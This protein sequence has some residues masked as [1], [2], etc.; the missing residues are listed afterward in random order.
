M[1]TTTT[2][3]DGDCSLDEVRPG[4]SV[5]AVVS[6]A[7]GNESAIGWVDGTDCARCVSQGCSQEVLGVG[8]RKLR[9]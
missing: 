4:V 8:E 2:V 1:M 9:W 6:L 3:V 5:T 7:T